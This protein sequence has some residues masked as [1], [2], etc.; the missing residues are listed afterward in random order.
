MGSTQL[1]DG[2]MS[3]QNMR[4]RVV[5][6]L[7]SRNAIAVENP[8]LP[9]TP[10]VNYVEG[11]IELKWLREWPVGEDTTVRFEHFTP[12]QRVFHIRRRLSGGVSWVLVQC[13]REWLLFDGATA[14]LHINQTTRKQLIELCLQY[15]DTGLKSEELLRWI[16]QGQKEFSYD[17]DVREKLKKLLRSG[18]VSQLSNL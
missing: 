17:A 12:Q 2:P 10:D 5:R 11:W 16:S 8:A 1:G 7:K 18:I 6:A 3:E 4:G 9:G 13:K 14:A 15:S